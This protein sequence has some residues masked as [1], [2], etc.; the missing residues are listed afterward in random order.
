MALDLAPK[1]NKRHSRAPKGTQRHPEARKGTQSPR[2]RGKTHLNFF[3]T[4]RGK[5]IY[6]DRS[7]IVRI[8]PSPPK[9]IEIE[10]EEI[11]EY[12]ED[13]DVYVEDDCFVKVYR[14]KN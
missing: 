13:D 3:R 12:I 11:V 10:P 1:D 8:R 14:V 9:I 7:E 6:L 5:V 4:V 2:T